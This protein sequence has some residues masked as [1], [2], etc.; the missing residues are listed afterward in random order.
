MAYKRLPD[1]TPTV[2]TLRLGPDLARA[3]SCLYRAEK[4]LGTATS[5]ADTIVELLEVGLAA[6]PLDAAYQISLR[7]GINQVRAYMFDRIRNLFTEMIV[8]LEAALTDVTPA[9]KAMLDEAGQ[10]E[11]KKSVEMP[12]VI[13]NQKELNELAK[14]SSL[15]ATRGRSSPRMG[16]GVESRAI[17]NKKKKVEEDIPEFVPI[18]EKS[19]ITKDNIDWPDDI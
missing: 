9:M 8:D 1:G 16:L 15:T 5:L 4:A 12:S 3:V 11:G 10:D 19:V 2:F 14:K 13:K 17:M 18:D 7:R 6:R